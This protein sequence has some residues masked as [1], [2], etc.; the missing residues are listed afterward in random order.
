MK[1]IQAWDDLT[2]DC[3]RE[4]ESVERGMLGFIVVEIEGLVGRDREQIES[5]QR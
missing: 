3:E 4:I 1:N 2:H 5:E